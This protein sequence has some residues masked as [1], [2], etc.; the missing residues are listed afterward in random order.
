MVAGQALTV[1][2]NLNHSLLT[3]EDCHLGDPRVAGQFDS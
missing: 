2:D 1:E 3:A